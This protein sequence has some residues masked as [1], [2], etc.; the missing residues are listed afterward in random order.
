MVTASSTTAAATVEVTR[1]GAENVK[2]ASFEI[3]EELFTGE[4]CSRRVEADVD[5]EEE[6]LGLGGEADFARPKSKEGILLMGSTLLC[7]AKK[8]GRGSVGAKGCSFVRNFPPLFSPLTDDAKVTTV[9]EALE[10][11]PNADGPGAQDFSIGGGSTFFI[12]EGVL[13]VA[14]DLVGCCNILADLEAVDLGLGEAD[15]T[16]EKSVRRGGPLSPGGE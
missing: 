5:T 4:G 16:G 13:D 9:G 14:D 2:E 15:C 6:G 8:D 1:D 3:T 10:E 12:T 7:A 11:L